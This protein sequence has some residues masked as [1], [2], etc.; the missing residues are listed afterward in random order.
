M[1]IKLN[2]N[3][4]KLIIKGLQKSNLKKRNKIKTYLNENKNNTIQFK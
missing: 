4:I 1:E 3:K 2:N